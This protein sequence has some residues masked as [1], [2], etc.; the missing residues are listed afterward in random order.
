MGSV[1]RTV[2]RICILILESKRL[3]VEI[4]EVFSPHHLPIQ[5]PLPPLPVLISTAGLHLKLNS[6]RLSVGGL[7]LSTFL[8]F[9]LLNHLI[10]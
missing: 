7:H 4:L 6:Y 8:L 5:L 3:K 10:V 9:P 1:Q 2:W